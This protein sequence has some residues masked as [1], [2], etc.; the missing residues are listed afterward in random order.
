[1]LEGSE[2]PDRLVLLVKRVRLGQWALTAPLAPRGQPVRP[3]LPALM[4]AMEKRVHQVRQEPLEQQAPRG[5]P[6][7]PDLVLRALRE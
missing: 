7:P 5:Q 2:R 1:M 6:V 4:V 3:V